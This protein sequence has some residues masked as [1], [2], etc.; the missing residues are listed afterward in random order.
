MPRDESSSL[1]EPQSTF[2]KPRDE[3]V[4]YEDSMES[5]KLEY[6]TLGTSARKLSAKYSIPRNKLNKIIKSEN[7][8]KYGSSRNGAKIKTARTA[9]H[10]KILGPTAQRKIKEVQ[11][12]LGDNYSPVDEP[13]LV[14]FAKSYERMIELE[15][16]IVHE[17]IVLTS[18][19][20][21]GKYLNPTFTALQ[22]VQKTLLTFANQLGLSMTSRKLLGIKL[23]GSDKKSEMSLFDIASDVNSMSIEI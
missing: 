11:E 18:E 19:K 4:G 8:L 21:G 3:G 20:T 1:P 22:A 15:L 2:D 10:S 6:E 9:S 14:A 23:G 13:L 12:E 7:W 17:G 5:A 16:T